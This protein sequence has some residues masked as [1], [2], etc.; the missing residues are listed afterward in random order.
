MLGTL[1][2]TDTL[3]RVGGEEFAIALPET[4]YEAARIAGERLRASIAD[5]LVRTTG[6][7]L[8]VTVSV[9]MATLTACDRD[10]G[11]LL[12]RADQA[13]YQAKAQG[14]NC[15]VAST[16][17]QSSAGASF[18]LS[19]VVPRAEGLDETAAVASR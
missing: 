13:L 16:G 11:D 6:G 8:R 5:S 14:R 19:G 4:G 7:L 10:F 17:A 1:R 15:V 2:A 9:G 18:G 12:R 3:G